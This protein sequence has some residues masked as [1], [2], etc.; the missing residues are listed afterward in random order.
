MTIPDVELSLPDLIR[1]LPRRGD[2]VPAHSVDAP[3]C[4]VLFVTAPA[5][6]SIPLHRH[7]TDNATVVVSGETVLT[8]EHGEQRYGPGQWYLTA[9]NEPH[10]VRFDVDTV[11]VELRFAVSTGDS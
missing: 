4:E 10:G 8:S 2:A 6:S 1:A 9:A 3:G 11:Q 7:E 5:G